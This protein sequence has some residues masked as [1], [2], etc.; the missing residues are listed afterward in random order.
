M[1]AVN[2]AMLSLIGVC[3]ELEIEC[4]SSIEVL[5][6]ARDYILRGGPDEGQVERCCKGFL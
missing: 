1:T 5:W 3:P 6:K 4:K 2:K